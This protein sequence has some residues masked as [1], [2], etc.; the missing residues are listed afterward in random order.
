MGGYHS[1]QASSRGSPNCSTPPYEEIKNKNMEAT[2]LLYAAAEEVTRLQ[3][4]GGTNYLHFCAP[5]QKPC[6]N[7][8]RPLFIQSVE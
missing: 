6:P 2:E 1:K 7:Q 3:Q 8:V 5:P 4:N